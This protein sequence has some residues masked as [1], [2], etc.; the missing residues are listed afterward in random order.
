[1]EA[2]ASTPLVVGEAI[3]Q[4]RQAKKY[5]ARQLS[6]EAGLSESYVGKLEAGEMEPSFR[7]VAK[8]VRVLG[9]KPG[10]VYVVLCEEA[11]G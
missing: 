8:L 6:L 7:A 2:G 10:E 4:F 11:R 3:R 9:M 1:M 5:S